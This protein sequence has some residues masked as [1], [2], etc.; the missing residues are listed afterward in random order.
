MR[1]FNDNDGRSKFI[2]IS[3]EGRQKQRWGVSGREGE[4]ERESR[5]R[6]RETEH[7]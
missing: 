1:L 4:R 5:L 7:G 3:N 6:E 2:F